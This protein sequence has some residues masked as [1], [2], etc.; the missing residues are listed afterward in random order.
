MAANFGTEVER[1][2]WAPW[3]LTCPPAGGC[4]SRRLWQ[5]GGCSNSATIS[6]GGFGMIARHIELARMR[7]HFAPPLVDERSPSLFA[8]SDRCFAPRLFL[9]V[10]DAR[11]N[12][13]PRIVDRLIRA[14]RA[15]EGA[16]TTSCLPTGS[17]S[18]IHVLHVGA[19][20]VPA[21]NT[22]VQ[23]NLCWDPLRYYSLQFPVA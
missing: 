10:H 14:V 18:I 20:R 9:I 23:Q 15:S 11:S 21:G 6:S 17:Q 16:L 13:F 12:P 5:G 2:Q 22:D 8:I 3:L 7:R 1:L 19:R 4:C